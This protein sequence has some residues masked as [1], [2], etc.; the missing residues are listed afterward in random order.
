MLNLVVVTNDRN[1]DSTYNCRFIKS[2]KQLLF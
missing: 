2:H 1:V